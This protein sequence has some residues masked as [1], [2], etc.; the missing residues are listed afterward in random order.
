MQ[1]MAVAKTSSAQSQIR[2][3]QELRLG[4]STMSKNNGVLDI[5]LRETLQILL[6][7]G[8]LERTKKSGRILTKRIL[9]MLFDYLVCGEEQSIPPTYRLSLV[10]PLN[11]YPGTRSLDGIQIWCC[12]EGQLGFVS[13]HPSSTVDF[14]VTYG[15]ECE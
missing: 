15:W 3:A 5:E 12:T 2:C 11:Y 7:R 9:V 8:T 13:S 4:K 10:H 6:P 14:G 1:K